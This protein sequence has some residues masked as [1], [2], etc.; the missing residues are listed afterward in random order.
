MQGEPAPPHL[1]SRETM[2]CEEMTRE[3]SSSRVPGTPLSPL[4]LAAV[5]RD[6]GYRLTEQ[7]HT[8]P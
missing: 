3:L 5:L 6:I 4:S 7:K 2:G 1:Q 8:P